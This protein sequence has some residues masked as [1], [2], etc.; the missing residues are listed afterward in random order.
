M[1]LN[2]KGTPILVTRPE[3][4]ARGLAAMVSAANGIPIV[5]PGLVIVP[6]GSDEPTLALLD[7][8]D[9]FAAAFFTSTNAVRCA[10]ALK[11]RRDWPAI[12][13]YAVGQ[14]T[15]RSLLQAGFPQVT[16]PQRGSGGE[17][18]LD[19]FDPAQ[20]GS[21][22]VVIL[23]A[24]DGRQDL[25][26]A[27]EAA[28]AEVSWCYVYQREPAQR[29]AVNERSVRGHWGRL[30][31]VATSAAIL[32]NV[33]AMFD[34]LVTRPLVVPSERLRGIARELGYT[35]VAVSARPDDEAL[36]EAATRFI[37]R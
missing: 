9:E 32:R 19:A 28:G 35:N 13:L 10:L 25:A 34:K 37:D 22:R 17:S 2:L 15:R 24:R 33:T 31:V 26:Q 5:Q 27:L 4:E 1:S 3:P 30:V 18:L 12:D 23:A 7:R 14:R 6:S 29:S 36:L 21:R 8:L 20:Y 16:G 11:A